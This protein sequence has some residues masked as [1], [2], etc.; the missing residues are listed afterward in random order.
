MNWIDETE[1]DSPTRPHHVLI[2]GQGESL[3]SGF[4]VYW[5]RILTESSALP[6]GSRETVGI[7]ILARDEDEVGAATA[8]FYTS[9]HE[10]NKDAPLYILR[11]DDLVCARGENEDHRSFTKTHLVWQL[12]QYLTLKQALQHS[13]VWP[14]FEKINASGPLRVQAAAAYGHFDLR[15]GQKEFGPLSAS[16]QSALAGLKPTLR[17]AV[18]N[19]CAGIVDIP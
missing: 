5:K 12:K 15:P 1:T 14:L 13:E 3:E 6:R 8:T 4:V 17:D 18:A 19:L 9:R 10:E 16:D 2:A 7:E 11:S